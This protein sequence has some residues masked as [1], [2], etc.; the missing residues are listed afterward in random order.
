[1]TF[2]IY[3]KPVTVPSLCLVMPIHGGC[4]IVE[5]G[6]GC[7]QHPGYGRLG[8]PETLHIDVSEPN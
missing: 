5:H 2:H 7:S 4:L 1:M 6:A 8:S 3:P